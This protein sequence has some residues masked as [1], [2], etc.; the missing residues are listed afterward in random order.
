MAEVL[1]PQ[2]RQAVE[3]RGGN[4]LVSAAAG[5]GKTK[6]LVDRLL[7]YILDSADPANIDDFLIITYTKA[8][9]A[10]LRA[11]IA[12]KLTELIAEDPQNR[13]LQQQMQ[14]LY[15][16]KI[17]TVHGFCAD[18]LREYAY[19]LDLSPD[20]RVADESECAQLQ[21]RALDEVLNHAYETA[22]TQADFRAFID[23]QGLGRDDR[24]IPQII[25]KVYQS[26]RCH[27]NPGQWLQWCVPDAQMLQ[28]TD[29]AQTPWGRYLLTDLKAYIKQQME[30]LNRCIDLASQ[31]QEMEKP[32]ALLTETVRQLSALSACETWDAVVDCGPVDYGRLVF[33]KKCPD[34]DLAEQIKA[35]RN[36]CKAGVEKRLRCF[37]DKSQVI[38]QDLS[39]CAGAAAGLI[40]LVQEFSKR[41]DTCKQARGVLDFGDL[42]HLTLDLLLGRSRGSTTAIA[43]EIGNRFREIMVDE[44]Q[45]SN[46]I[47]DAIFSALTQKRKNCFMVGDVK[48]S[49]YQFRLADPGI[50]LEKYNTYAPAETAAAGQGRKILLSNNFRSSGGVIEGVNDVFRFCMSES[51]GGLHYGQE[52]MLR[53]GIPHI[54]LKEPEVSLLAIGVDNDTYAEEAGIV[55]DEIAK[56]LDGRHYVRDQDT[57]RPVRAEDIAILL[58]SPGSVGGE[59]LSALQSRGIRCVTGDSADLLRTEE[60]GTLIS[61][62]QILHNP[63]Q[64]IPLAAVLTSPV[65]GFT[66]EDLS[67]LRSGDL[68]SN[69]YQLLQNATDSKSV[70]IISVLNELR[71]QARLL[72]VTQLL[73]EVFLRTNM[74]SIYA[75]MPGGEE[76]LEN[77]QLFYQTTSDYELSGQKDLGRFLE[78]LDAAQ[79]RGLGKG[80]ARQE[81][82]AVTLMS[83]HKSKGLEFPVVFLSGLSRG[84]NQES[85]RQQV[86][87]DQELGLGLNCVDP[88][89]RIRYPS[90]AKRAIS[91]KILQQGISEEM[92]VLYVAMTRARD[93]LIMTY[94][95]KYL[96]SDLQ[97]IGQRLKLSSRELMTAEV[98]CPGAWILQ[99]AMTRT[100]A[101]ELFAIGGD[102]G[103]GQPSV[104]PWEIR[105]HTGVQ[106]NACFEQSEKV[107]QDIS[108]EMLAQLSKSVSFN[109]SHTPATRIPSK[110]TATQL[111]GRQK[112]T[113]VSE[114]TA[115]HSPTGF[116]VPR[117]G[118]SGLR[119][120]DYGNAIHAVLQYIRFSQCNT[121]DG[122]RAE[123]QRLTAEQLISPEQAAVVDYEKIACF[124]SS[125][126]G[127]KLCNSSSV[128]RE[129][130]FSILD[131][132]S[133]YYAD[134]GDEQIL[135]QGVVDCAV[136]EDDGIQVIDFKTDYVT[137]DTIQAVADQ[138]RPQVTAYVRAMERIYQKPV[139]YA[140][141]YFFGLDRFVEV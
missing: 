116:R 129:F 48:Q 47:Q 105:V 37:T 101:G 98:D 92:R 62:L 93:R 100:E 91:R 80:G 89:Q 44:Y 2:Q 138:Y 118:S 60:I 71:Q 59:F 67:V 7:Q 107:Q 124:F 114:G 61:I 29:A 65:F 126:F 84:F 141:L 34:M 75:A 113:E 17:S 81:S 53:E 94:A 87:C 110:L 64:D 13:H 130:K 78:F 55:A 25:L 3:N 104:Q 96:Q 36:N 15:L 8:A 88:V 32:V 35:I 111:K 133:R 43:T 27:L 41:Y 42:E 135:L 9:A 19:R 140:A 63:L 52:E 137:E 139:T 119:G 112:D 18:I 131:D 123:I 46:A 4:L 21:L 33:S 49:I 115:N 54:P 24:Q 132:A 79:E 51:V 50:F 31:T 77:L 26:A 108:R 86:L 69:L 72:S 57:L 90:V 38:L 76:K 95:S 103:C 97:D 12:S 121:I 40:G 16:A 73:G 22:E 5:S 127:R 122:I 56:L 14:R 20:F 83:I 58:R 120:K 125:E 10:E 66:A 39:Q 85:V 11:K 102:P 117:K 128:L 30:T 134:A 45:D 28:K 6:V 109:Y 68:H 74:L 99:S 82:G 70:A 23:T 1:T 106:A 136:V